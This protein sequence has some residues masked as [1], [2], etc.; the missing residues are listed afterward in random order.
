LI[1][2]QD[3]GALLHIPAREWLIATTAVDAAVEAFPAMGSVDSGQLVSFYESFASY[4]TDQESFEPVAE[5][6]A[7][8]VRRAKE[9]GDTTTRLILDDG[10]RQDMVA[11]LRLWA[12][13]QGARDEVIE[14]IQHDG[15]ALEHVRSGLGVV[16][17]VFEGRPNVFA[18]ACGVLSG[19][20]TVVFRIGSSAL[21]TARAMIDHAIGPALKD[22]GLPEGAVSLV[23][24]PSRATGW[25]LFSDHRLGLAVARGSGAAVTQLGAVAR[26]TGIP[27][28]LHGT[29]GAWIVA[30]ESAEPDAFGSAVFHSLDRKVCNTL[31]T[32]CIVASRAHELVPVFLDAL[33]RAG[34]RR[35]AT[36]KL[37]VTPSARPFI[38]DSWFGPA[39]IVRAGGAGAEARTQLIDVDRLGVE[40]EWEE[41]PE[42]TLTVVPDVT[43]AVALFN[44]Q[45]PRL[46]ASL[47]SVDRDEHDHFF[48]VI[49]APFVGNGFTRWVDGQYALERPELGLSNWQFGRLF[50][51]GGILSGDSIYTIRTR[52]YQA[53]PDLGR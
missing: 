10:M 15:W 16:G 40:W 36:S 13:S 12:G 51:R 14:T 32:A 31:N 34:E 41:S 38:P 25:A 8:D 24:S 5:A 17:F 7:D 50:G 21:G 42:V 9:R 52:A 6:N 23:D 29:G 4:L 18:D 49:D 37:H 48:E 28:S 44:T 47:I 3:S 22:A 30:A 39:R 45:S 20:N 19:G 35:G 46:A 11:G 2:V 27:V 33:D 1:V 26:Q 43:A 53:D